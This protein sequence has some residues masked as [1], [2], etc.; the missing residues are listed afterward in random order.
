MKINPN[1]FR[2]YDIRG[3]YP[4]EI[5]EET[6]YFLG[7]AFPKF[8]GKKNLKIVVGRDNRLS[9]PLLFKSLTKGLLEEGAN[10]IDIGLSTSPG[11]YFSV[12]HFGFDGGVQI[13][14]SHCHREFN[15]FKLVREQAI[16]LSIETGLRELKKI[17]G[18]NSFRTHSKKSGKIEK[19]NFL[20]NYLNFHF[21]LADLD[22]IK[23][24]KIVIDTA[25]TVS[26][27][28]LQALLKRLP[29]K[30]YHLFSELDGNFPNHPPNPLI[31]ENLRFLIKE[32]KNKK[33]DL[34]LALDGDGDRIIFIDEKGKII[35]GDFITA[36]IGQELLK[37]NPGRK[38]LYEVRS[39]QVV[40]E[41]ILKNR[42][43]PILGRAGHSLIK[44]QMAKENIFFAGELSGHY[45]F[46][47]IGFFEAPLL[48]ILKLLK[49]MS[50]EN[51]PLSKIIQPFKIYFQSGE[52]NFKVK[53][54]ERKIEKIEEYYKTKDVKEIL[55]LDG[56]TVKGR[57]WWF[58][59]RHSGTEDLLR[60]NIEAKTKKLLEQKKKQLTLLILKIE[61]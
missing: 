23:P 41:V 16:P 39:S 55:H 61:N 48:V 35:R 50:R 37:E 2:T 54:Q 45:C 34:G 4:S 59:L 27:L 36:L 15:G 31:K 22:E 14:A 53:N 17:I 9:S 24:L 6:A 58:N 8:L 25:N 42:G 38:I 19:K 26:G 30:I 18:K 51:K 7:R 29:G 40:K 28:D 12:A 1:I 33:A 20:E 11:L 56:I 21:K 3:I 46:K 47:E 49:I 44:E 32:I 5:N 52:L 60:L 57:G 13:T 43:V 10:V